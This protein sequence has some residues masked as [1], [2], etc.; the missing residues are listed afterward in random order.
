MNSV[1]SFTQRRTIFGALYKQGLMS[2]SKNAFKTFG[3]PFEKQKQREFESIS[4]QKRT[5]TLASQGPLKLEW[6]SELPPSLP[7]SGQYPTV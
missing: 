2:F 5:E 7:D 4:K 6:P 3:L 1:A